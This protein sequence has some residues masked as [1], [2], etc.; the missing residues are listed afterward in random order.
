MALSEAF[1]PPQSGE[2]PAYDPRWVSLIFGA[3]MVGLVMAF[4]AS[5]PNASR[6][7]GDSLPGDAFRFFKQQA[8]FG[9][10]PDE[11]HAALRPEFGHRGTARLDAG[12]HVV[13]HALLNQPIY[14]GNQQRVI[15][16]AGNA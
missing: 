5:Y 9:A 15:E 3:V 14:R 12:N 10:G 1:T 13:L 16:L 4:S 11:P 2:Q 8:M 7:G 6:A